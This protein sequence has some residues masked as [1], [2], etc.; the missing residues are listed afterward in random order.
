[1]ARHTDV[2]V[3]VS[4]VLRNEL[5]TA[6]Q[7]CRVPL[8]CIENGIDVERYSPG[9][10]PA[11]LGQEL[12][13]PEHGIVIGSIGRLESVK[14]Y[15]RLLQAFRLL[16]SSL[17]NAPPLYLVI[18]GDGSERGRLETLAAELALSEWVRWCGWVT[19]P[20]DHYRL[21]DVFALTS[22][23]EG[24]PLSLL[25]AMACGIAPVVTDVG[26]NRVV[27]GAELEGQAI[28]RDNL[29]GIAAALA[30]LVGSRDLRVSVGQRARQ[31]VVERYSLDRMVT[32]Y[33]SV[34]R[35]AT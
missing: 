18:A 20:L 30:A 9:P 29:H 11:R 21:C 35:G 14:R 27:L 32:A 25:E 15:D 8:V 19:D 1:A 13:I 2:V 23:T 33:E 10:R 17:V 4:D 28:T 31:R 5:T 12:G 22:D 7:G 6:L 34:Y 16:K 3:C 26:V 24:I